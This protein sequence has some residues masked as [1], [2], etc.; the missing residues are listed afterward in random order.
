VDKESTKLNFPGRPLALMERQFLRSTLY[1]GCYKVCMRDFMSFGVAQLNA[2]SHLIDLN[3]RIMS[4]LF[5]RD[6]WLHMYTCMYPSKADN[7]GFQ[8][9]EKA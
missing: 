8:T 1:I 7:N 3:N 2:L 9:T 6:Y 4:K 5:S